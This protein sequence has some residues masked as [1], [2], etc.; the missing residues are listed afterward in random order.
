MRIRI[1]IAICGVAAIALLAALP[2]GDGAGLGAD[3][4]RAD[5]AGGDWCPIGHYSSQNGRCCQDDGLCYMQGLPRPYI[6]DPVVTLSTPLSGAE[7]SETTPGDPDGT[8][9]ITVTTKP[10]LSQVCFTIT[11]NNINLNA[12]AG[13]I[14]KAPRGQSIVVPA[15][16]LLENV[17]AKNTISQC[18]FADPAT[19]R[20]LRLNPRAYYAQVHNLNYPE[21]AIRG[22]FGD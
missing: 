18:R 5:I 22:Q 21:G 9:Y 1:W 11:M 14:H 10:S 4:S 3:V 13:H 7:Q 2:P 19:I 6:Y 20:D 12:I 17:N 16:D 8:G 15:V